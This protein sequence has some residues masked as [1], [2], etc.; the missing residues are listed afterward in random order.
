MFRSTDD[1]GERTSLRELQAG[2][3]IAACDTWP[4]GRH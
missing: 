2:T 4:A 3:E 1:V